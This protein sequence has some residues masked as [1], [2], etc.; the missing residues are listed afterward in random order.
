MLCTIY[1]V[2]VVLQPK[3]DFMYSEGYVSSAGSCNVTVISVCHSPQ[4]EL[5]GNVFFD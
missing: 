1:T 2:S 3:I 5:L 4:L